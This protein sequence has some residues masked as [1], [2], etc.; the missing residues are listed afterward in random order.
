MRYMFYC[1][2]Q[3]ST[4]FNLNLSNWNTSS[5]TNMSSM[6]NAVGYK[7][8]SWS[9]T[10]PKT[11]GSLTNTTSTWYGSSESTYASPDTGKSFTLAS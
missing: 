2:G 6:F 8:T 7:A 1:A 4:T 5:V 9:V 3:N 10:I 11:T